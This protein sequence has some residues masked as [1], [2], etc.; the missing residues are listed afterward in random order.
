[1]GDLL[2]VPGIL[3]GNILSEN[4]IR[5]CRT[6]F[7]Y[8]EKLGE[9]KD[10]PK[11]DEKKNIIIQEVFVKC[12]MKIVLSENNERYGICSN[13]MLLDNKAVHFNPQEG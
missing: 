13:C 9:E 3:C 11:T 12:I 6:D 4:A 1:M 7:V 5:Y 2:T 10:T 8:A